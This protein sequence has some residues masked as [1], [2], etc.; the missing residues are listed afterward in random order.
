MA[1]IFWDFNAHWTPWKSF[2]HNLSTLCSSNKLLNNISSLSVFLC[3][4]VLNLFS[5]HFHT[6]YL[7]P[8]E[9]AFK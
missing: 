6:E 8:Y 5:M 4:L 7:Q 1:T 3:V 9:E 2:Q